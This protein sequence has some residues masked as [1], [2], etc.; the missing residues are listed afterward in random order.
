MQNTAFT[1]PPESAT[2][3]PSSP[4]APAAEE[5]TGWLALL[6]RCPWIWQLALV[7]GVGVGCFFLGKL[8]Q[9]NARDTGIPDDIFKTIQRPVAY[10]YG[11][12]VVTRAELGEYLIDR[13]GAD[14]LDFMLNRKIVEMECSKHGITATQA[15]VDAR[16]QDDL[17]KFGTPMTQ[18]EFVNSILRRFG[19]TLYEWKEDVIRPK[20]M[21]EKLVRAK[22]TIGDKDIREGFDAKYGPKVECRMIV[23]EKDNAR[24]AQQVFDEAKKGRTQFLEQARKCFIPGLAQAEGKIPPIH[25][26]FGDKDIE[27]VAFRL[28]ENEVGPLMKMQDGTYVILFCEKQLP[29]NAA[30][31]YEDVRLEI[32][33]E[34]RELRIAQKIPELFTELHKKAMPKKVLDNGGTP[35]YSTVV[36][37]ESSSP[38]APVINNDVPVKVPPPP[39]PQPI[40]PPSGVAPLP[41]APSPM[42]VPILRPMDPAPTPMPPVVPP[43]KK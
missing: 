9:A 17:R 42:A 3:A 24:V 22:V 36:S 18:H 15:E 39:T 14:R 19:K 16:F 6:Q 30:V 8:R 5:S 41:E 38:I 43:G 4:A 40:T 21:M 26:H 31:R 34:M 35:S 12:M 10:I 20:I 2:P 29:A 25:K 23:I 33:K 1:K 32:S 11:D 37:P 28:R 27:D 7:I 13:F